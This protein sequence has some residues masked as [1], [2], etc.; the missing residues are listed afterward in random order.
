MDM[1]LH[2]RASKSCST[3][4]NSLDLATVQEVQEGSP[5]QVSG[6]LSVALVPSDHSALVPSDHS[7]CFTP[8]ARGLAG[9]GTYMTA[10]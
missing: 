8:P 7:A 9:P 2:R 10:T 4:R 5:S 3:E 1:M 6:L